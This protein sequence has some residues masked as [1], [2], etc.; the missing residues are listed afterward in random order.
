MPKKCKYK[1]VHVKWVF[2]HHTNLTWINVRGFPSICKP[3]C[4]IHKKVQI[5]LCD[6]IYAEKCPVYYRVKYHFKMICE[7][8]RICP[9]ET[10]DCRIKMLY[11]VCQY[12]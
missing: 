6:I 5:N 1:W 11:T 8:N 2:Y 12:T 3:Q 9:I 4:H 7:E 10:Q